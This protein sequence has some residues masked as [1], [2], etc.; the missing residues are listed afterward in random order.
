MCNACEFCKK[1]PLVLLA[2]VAIIITLIIMYFKKPAAEKLSSP[3]ALAEPN[4]ATGLA[5]Y[6]EDVARNSKGMTIR[7]QDLE[8]YMLTKQLSTP[9]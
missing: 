9:W 2:I 4:I 7:D 5:R 6:G 3:W 8:K 1:Y